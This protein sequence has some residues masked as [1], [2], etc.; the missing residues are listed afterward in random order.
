MPKKQSFETD[1][2]DV[3]ITRKCHSYI[4]SQKQRG[5][6]F[7][8]FIDMMAYAYKN[9]DA[10][11]EAEEVRME[12]AKMCKM[13]KDKYFEKERELNNYKQRIQVTM[14]EFIKVE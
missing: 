1:L 5:E 11:H 10:L 14:E 12:T 8:H 13:W 3:R 6:P 2:V 9:N 7:Y 4:L